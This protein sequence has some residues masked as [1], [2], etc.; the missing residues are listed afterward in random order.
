MCHCDKSFEEFQHGH[1]DGYF[2]NKNASVSANL[3]FCWPD[4]L[5]VFSSI[6]QMLLG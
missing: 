5:H 3:L 4:A 1:H 6:K 2:A